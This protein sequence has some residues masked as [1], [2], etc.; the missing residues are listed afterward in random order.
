MTVATPMTYGQNSG[1]K[2]LPPSNR[3]MQVHI[4]TNNRLIKIGEEL[5]HSLVITTDEQTNTNHVVLYHN[6]TPSYFEVANP[7][8]AKRTTY[9][10]NIDSIAYKMTDC[11]TVFNIPLNLLIAVKEN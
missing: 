4:P 9:Q 10:V 1:P 6:K 11:H 3:R 7:D 8:K 2:P 5:S